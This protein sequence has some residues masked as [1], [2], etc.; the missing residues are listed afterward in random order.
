MDIG[1]IKEGLLNKK[2]VSAKKQEYIIK[3]EMLPKYVDEAVLKH[4]GSLEGEV[5]SLYN[6]K[7]KLENDIKKLKGLEVKKELND[8]AEMEYKINQQQERN[9]KIILFKQS[10]CQ[11]VSAYDSHEYFVNSR[12]VEMKYWKGLL[13]ELLPSGD[14]R[15]ALILSDIN[16]KLGELPV[17]PVESLYNLFNWDSFINDMKL[18]RLPINLTADGVMLPQQM[19]LPNPGETK[20]DPKLSDM[21]KIDLERLKNVDKDVRI[22]FISL[23]KLLGSY[24]SRLEAS[25]L[26]QRAILSEMRE[27]ELTNDLLS[28]DNETARNNLINVLDKVQQQNDIIVPLSLSET[29]A[30]F[31]A[32]SSETVANSLATSLKKTQERLASA[33]DD[34]SK[35]AKLEYAED[36]KNI[37]DLVNAKEK[38]K[39]KEK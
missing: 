23:Y 31:S 25:E 28:K 33:G 16:N 4:I 17:G 8:V 38:V 6:E 34:P 35:V 39:P 32:S 7:D 19:M 2:K 1:K 10:P 12:G 21:V 5:D 22:G 15:L 18:G 24:Q 26:K 13:F 14:T 9:K 11:I 36:L 29:E 3:A 37:L 27:L 20:I 30:R